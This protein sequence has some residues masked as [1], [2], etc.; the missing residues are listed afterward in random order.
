ML[1]G[2]VRGC[3]HGSATIVSTLVYIW[4]ILFL[5]TKWVSRCAAL[6]SVMLFLLVNINQEL[7]EYPNIFCCTRFKGSLLSMCL[8][9]WWL[10]CF[11]VIQTNFGNNAAA[12][13]VCFLMIQCMEQLSLTLYFGCSLVLAEK[14]Q[15][16]KT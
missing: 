7:D 8:K 13:V 11:L 2:G 10:T 12:H 4:F 1:I 5:M 6:L 15:K 14:K 9:Y 16:H 3:L